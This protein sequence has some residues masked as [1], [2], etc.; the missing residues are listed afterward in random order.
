MDGRAHL[1]SFEYTKR[2]EAHMLKS[3]LKMTEMLLQVLRIKYT[4][5][6]K[7]KKRRRMIKTDSCQGERGRR[8]SVPNSQPCD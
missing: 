4:F 5:L 1:K 7:K 2:I 3:A 8:T 6:K